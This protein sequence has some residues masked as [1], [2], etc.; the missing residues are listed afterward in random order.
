MVVRRN[1]E[2]RAN[3]G[4]K[5]IYRINNPWLLTLCF[6]QSTLKTTLRWIECSPFTGD[7][8][9]T[10]VARLTVTIVLPVL[11]RAGC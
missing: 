6:P 3:G 9:F 8:E 1:P 5:F 2:K 7:Q 10:L 4:Y 11:S